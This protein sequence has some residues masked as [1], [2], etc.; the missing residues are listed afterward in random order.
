MNISMDRHVRQIGRNFGYR[1]LNSKILILPLPERIQ[2]VRIV[3]SHI[4]RRDTSCLRWY[5]YL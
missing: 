5:D 2:K 1:F 3:F 4:V